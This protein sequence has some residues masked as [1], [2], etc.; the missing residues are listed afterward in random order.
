MG[1]SDRAAAT[2]GEAP[3]STLLQGY[4]DDFDQ[5]AGADREQSA[6]RLRRGEQHHRTKRDE[7]GGNYSSRF[8][9]RRVAAR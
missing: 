4:A 3:L 1:T 2:A 8:H 5:D 9:G 7:D 6:E